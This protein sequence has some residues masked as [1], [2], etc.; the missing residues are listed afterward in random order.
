MGTLI[1]FEED[2]KSNGTGLSFRASRPTATKRKSRY[3]ACPTGRASPTRSSG[4]IG[5]ANIDVD[6]IVQNVGHDGLTDFSF[7]VHRNDYR[8]HAE[9]PEAGAASTSRRARVVSGDERSRRFRSSASA[10][11][12]TPASRARLFRALA[13]E[14]INIQ[15]IS[16]SEIKISVVIDEKYTELAVRVLH[17]V[18]EPRPA[19]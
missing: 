17:K 3:S 1:T 2:R 18:F 14:G 16:T 4:P 11:A 8:A 9:D 19:G 5:D 13:E 7:T 12:R 10:C 6:M 15:M